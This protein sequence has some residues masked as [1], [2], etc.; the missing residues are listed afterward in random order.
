MSTW[1][2]KLVQQ[3]HQAILD[4]ETNI[5]NLDVQ[6]NVK[7]TGKSGASHQIDV[8][9]EFRI[10]DTLYRTCIECRDYT[11]SIKKSRVVEF[12]GIL[13]DIGNANGIIVTRVGFQ[14]GALTYA[15]HHRIRLLL[16]NP[17]LQKIQMNM[18]VVIPRIENVDFSFDP[19][20]A[21]SVLEAANTQ[22]ASIPLNGSP[23]DIYLHDKDGSQIRSLAEVLSQPIGKTGRISV[24]LNDEYLKTEYGLIKLSSISFDRQEDVTEE[25]MIVGGGENIAQTVIEDVLENTSKYLFNDGSVGSKPRRDQ[26]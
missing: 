9:W 15:N 4:Q 2:E 20:H 16:I 21:R 22:S 17:V 14:E 25:Q 1:Y 26:P 3:T 6:H 8:Y 10:A 5:K 12:K 7:L 11:S 18:H 13:D 24:N 19:E 23:R